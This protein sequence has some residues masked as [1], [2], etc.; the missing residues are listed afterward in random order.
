MEVRYSFQDVKG[1]SENINQCN[2]LS[3]SVLYR[4]ILVMELAQ[5]KKKC[6]KEQ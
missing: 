2:K 3:K 5:K 1:S 4:G 6:P